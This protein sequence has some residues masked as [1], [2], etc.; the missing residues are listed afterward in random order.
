MVEGWQEIAA[1]HGITETPNGDFRDLIGR[2]Y[3]AGEIREAIG[4]SS[5]GRVNRLAAL[6]ERV[7]LAMGR[8]HGR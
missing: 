7:T 1:N 5:N 8:T 4:Y 3:T 2:T 6:K